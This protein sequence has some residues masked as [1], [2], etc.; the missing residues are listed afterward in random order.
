MTD[1]LEVVAKLPPPD[2][3]T[4]SQKFF[5]ATHPAIL[6]LYKEYWSRIEVTAANSTAPTV[7]EQEA[8]LDSIQ[9]DIEEHQEE[10]QAAFQARKDAIDEFWKK[11]SK[12]IWIIVIIIIVIVI[13]V[14]VAPLAIGAKFMNQKQ[15]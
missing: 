15:K 6:A 8:V 10:V 7:E 5:L 12:I 4:T 14:T 2:Q 3:L 11:N 1:P 13:I 9:S